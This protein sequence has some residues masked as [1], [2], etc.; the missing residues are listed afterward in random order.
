MVKE[1]SSDSTFRK[2]VKTMLLNPARRHTA[3]LSRGAA[4][5]SVAEVETRNRKSVKKE[6]LACD[7]TTMFILATFE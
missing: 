1:Q 5:A 4:A 2:R 3:R 6:Y 7:Q